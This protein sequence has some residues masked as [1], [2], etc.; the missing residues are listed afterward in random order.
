MRLECVWSLVLFKTKKVN[1]V[2][3]SKSFATQRT[4]SVRSIRFRHIFLVSVLNKASFA[5][6][7]N[8]RCTDFFFASLQPTTATK[9]KMEQ[10]LLF[11]LCCRMHWPKYSFWRLLSNNHTLSLNR[12]AVVHCSDGCCLYHLPYVVINFCALFEQ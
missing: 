11:R 9:I 12:T 10:L 2:L 7:Q 5:N 3:H 1:F 4:R 6:A 8:A